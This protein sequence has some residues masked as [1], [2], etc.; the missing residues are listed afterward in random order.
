MW[1]GETPEKKKNSSHFQKLNLQQKEGGLVEMKEVDR[2]FS[3]G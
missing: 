1:E 3:Q 2:A